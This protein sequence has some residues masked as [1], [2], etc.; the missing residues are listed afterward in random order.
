MN[1][2]AEKFRLKR[3]ELRLSQQTLAEGI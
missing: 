2:L 3:K 1:T